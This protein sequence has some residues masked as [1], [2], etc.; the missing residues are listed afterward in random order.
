MLWEPLA[1]AA[2]NQPPDQAAAPVFARVLAEMF[3]PRSAAAAILLPT[4][5]LHLMYAE[6]ARAVHRAHGGTVRTGAAA[7]C[8]IDRRRCD[9][10]A[11]GE[12]WS[13]DAV[14][15]AVPW[16]ALRELFDGDIAALDDDRSIA[17]AG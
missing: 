11:A 6:P 5:P 14:I 12:R 1:L 9:V 15:A 4:R 13:P 7:S 17:P 3:G 10:E 8:P 16:F 2:L